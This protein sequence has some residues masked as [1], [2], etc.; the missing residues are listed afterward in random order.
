MKHFYKRFNSPLFIPI[1]ALAIC[2]VLNLYTIFSINQFDEKIQYVNNHPFNVSKAAYK[3]SSY[4]SIMHIRMLR[5]FMWRT[6]DDLELISVKIN[7]DLEI[8]K[9]NYRYLEQNYLGD[10]KEIIQL[11]VLI[12]NIYDIY[13][14]LLGDI[15]NYSVDELKVVLDVECKEYNVEVESITDN[16]IKNTENNISDAVKN[17]EQTLK[18]NVIILIIISITLTILSIVLFFSIKREKKYNKYKEYLLN[19]SENLDNVFCIY[20]IKKKKMDY[21]SNNIERVIGIERYIIEDNPMNLLKNIDLELSNEVIGIIEGGDKDKVIDKDFIYTL[22]N[23]KSEKWM[24]LKIFPVLD[25]RIVIRYIVAI[26]DIDDSKKQEKLL[27]DAMVNSQSANEAKTY[28]MSRMSHDIRNPLNAIIGMT[29]IAST[30]LESPKE[31]MSCLQNIYDASNMLLELIND[32]LDVSKIENE[33]YTL[34]NES[35]T[36]EEIISNI[37]SVTCLQAKNKKI[38]FVIENNLKEYK[39]LIGDSLKLKQILMNLL[40]NAIKFTPSGGKVSLFINKISIVRDKIIRIRFTISDTG[41]G[42]TEN[43][44]D[45]LFIPFEQEGRDLS[46]K[47]EG[48]GLGM[49]IVKSLVFMMNGTV[50]VNSEVN[51]GSV[52]TVEIPF[53]I[54]LQYDKKN[55]EALNSNSLSVKKD[56]GINCVNK[57]FLLVDDNEINLEIAETFLK[58]T[59]ADVECAI[60]GH[61]AIEMFKASPTG[62]YDIIFMDIRMPDLDGY[63]TTRIIRNSDHLDASKIKIVALTANAYSE[64]ISMA[65]D[66]GMNMHIAKPIDIKILYEVIQYMIRE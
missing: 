32:V 13:T 44:M 12:D 57:R 7:E 11:G 61:L 31:V 65:Q 60:N 4:N 20:N 55:I 37:S 14:M 56:Y 9:E 18:R 43:F 15:D 23:S 49:S 35:F 48:S 10:P 50:E 2:L 34:N 66:A 17:S 42:I 28:F 64:D 3:V 63:E 52:F 26:Y 25:S 53:L 1:H 5:L 46:E 6:E 40:S 16:I 62:Y 58:T 39:P 51:M 24:K 29:T 22:P 36:M 19:L 41:I 21:I 45:K 59:G 54:G 33:R 47:N 30:K 38:H 27:K 8:I